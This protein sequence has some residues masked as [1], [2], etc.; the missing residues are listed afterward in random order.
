MQK[1]AQ[2]N[3]QEVIQKYKLL[4]QETSAL[5]QKM[6]EIEDEKKEHEYA[7]FDI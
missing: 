4:Q 3:E 5:V 1:S 6:M 2:D 7:V